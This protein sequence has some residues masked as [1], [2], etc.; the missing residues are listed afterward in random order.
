MIR[1]EDV[2]KTSWRRTAETNILVLT[3][4]SSRCLQDVFW[5]HKAKVNIF[6]SIKT[7]SSSRLLKTKKKDVF[8]TSS[9]RLHQDERLLGWWR[10]GRVTVK[11]LLAQTVNWKKSKMFCLHISWNLHILFSLVLVNSHNQWIVSLY[12]MASLVFVVFN[13]LLYDTCWGSHQVQRS[14]LYTWA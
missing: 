6:V 9:R 7:S 1:L 8:K 13:N 10:L 4:T 3:K 5:R 12:F 2:L 14:W 11:N